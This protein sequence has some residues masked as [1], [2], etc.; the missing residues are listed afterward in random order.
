MC[1][2]ADDCLNSNQDKYKTNTAG[3][4]DLFTSIFQVPAL[5]KCLCQ[6]DA[7]NRY[8]ICQAFDVLL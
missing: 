6:E 7:L 8:E 2:D 4:H 1:D 5:A 3:Y